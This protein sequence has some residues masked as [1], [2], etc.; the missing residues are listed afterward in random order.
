MM[1]RTDPGWRLARVTALFLAVLLPVHV[2]VVVL[3][4][5]IGRTTFAT[6]SARLSGTWWPGLEWATLVL[7]LGH[8]H[9][10][11]RARLAR[12]LPP[13]RRRDGATVAV[14][15]VAV[16]LGLGATGAMLTFS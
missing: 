11:L 8:G 5:D 10:V 4:D 15:A 14:G 6:V 1:Q 16:M 7:A 9:L 12:S 3:R 13:G 2:A